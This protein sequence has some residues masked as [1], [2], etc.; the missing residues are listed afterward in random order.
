VNDP[1]T[2]RRFWLLLIL[3]LA[4]IA[5]RAADIRQVF[6]GSVIPRMAGFSYDIE[7]GHMVVAFVV[8]KEITG[9]STPAYQAGLQQG[10][11]ILAVHNRRGE[12]RTLE[13]LFDYGAAL[14]RIPLDE[15]WLV[16]VER[17][18]PS[19]QTRTAELVVPPS[20]DASRRDVRVRALMLLFYLILP[21]VAI[22]T[23]FFIGFMRPD[24]P[25]AFLA[26]IL[27]LSFSTIFETN[28]IS[29]PAVLREFALLYQS[30]LNSF[31]GYAFLRFFLLF[32]SPSPVERKAPW[33][34]SAALSLAIAFALIA[35]GFGF[36]AGYSFEAF[37]RLSAVLPYIETFSALSALLMFV[38]GVTSL[39]V[40]TARA[41]S[42][43]ERRRLVIL[44][45]GTVV[46]L[47]PLIAFIL[48]SRFSGLP[49]PPWWMFAL[50]G[51]TLGLFPLSF[52]YVVLRHR[53][54]GI[55]LIVKRGLRYALVSRGFLVVEAVL[56]FLAFFFGARPLLLRFYPETDDAAFVLI[57]VCT[58]LIAVSALGRV[59]RR[60]MPA[61]DRRFFR[62]AYDARTVLTELSRSVRRLVTDPARLLRTVTDTI[63]DSFLPEHVA[64]FLRGKEAWSVVTS[65]ETSLQ[66]L[67][68]FNPRTH[69]DLHLC[70]IRSRSESPKRDH[71]A[72]TPPDPIVLPADSFLARKIE[73]AAAVEAEALDVFLTDPKSWTEPLLR[74]TEESPLYVERL[75]LE[76]VGTRLLVPLATHDHVL[77]FLSLGEKLSEEPYSK[78]DKALLLAVAE[79][80]AVA[81][82]YAHLVGQVAE[83]E[84]LKRD[85]EIAKQV[86]M[87]L[88]PQTHPVMRTLDY[89]A[90]CR[91]AREVGGDY[92]DFLQLGADDL[93]LALGDI[94]GKGLSAS[95]LM[96]GLQ[97]LLRSQAPLL[98][99]SP[100]ALISD[101]NR[102]MCTSS[103][104]SKYATFFC[105]VYSDVERR[106]TYVN[107]GHN[108]PF[109]FRPKGNG[110]SSDG[111]CEV[112][113]LTT[114]GTVVGLFPEADYEQEALGLLPGDVMVVFTDGVTE[115]FNAEREEFGE[116]RLI[117]AVHGN[118]RLT[119]A[120]IRERIL[121]RVDKFVGK[122]AQH[123]DLT[124]LVLKVS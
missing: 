60:I 110:R 19:G 124:L 113:R 122:A 38:L 31:L 64:L 84:R 88:Y 104:G 5:Y 95:L 116:R 71:A 37:G 22:S 81:L 90:V 57:T 107:A 89:T 13:G 12:G 16:T 50:V 41:E 1:Q 87:Q 32:P 66:S 15:S 6:F 96:A 20:G 59:N 61:I 68:H 27:F 72:N 8:E 98:G 118:L 63:S 111:D 79:Q 75:F 39:V 69:G 117:E 55:R 45:A 120:D 26:A 54:L 86:Q 74:A 94:S 123:D 9:T 53:V 11:R 52:V 48:Y 49:I 10:D 115:A 46:G 83:Q 102:L 91:P 97:A 80:T 62:E 35:V 106:L 34:K 101:I 121:H 78:E 73:R 51:L 33:I 2:Q 7:Q 25:H 36:L 29:F 119:A 58:T 82:D 44:L 65:E 14:R 23:A 93:C 85:I 17:V 100:R 56:I 99:H 67:V 109:L 114:G 70:W 77:G 3:A 103:D 40:N 112:I 28:I 92:Y 30:V 43:D 18:D 47:V 42:Q 21:L 105:G 4:T 76:R 108:P 24:N